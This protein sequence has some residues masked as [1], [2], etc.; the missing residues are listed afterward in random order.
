MSFPSTTEIYNS[1][2][3][4]TLI[5]MGRKVV[6]QT[7]QKKPL[8]FWLSKKQRVTS[9]GG[10][11]IQ[12]PIQ[13]REPTT[14]KSFGRGDSFDQVDPDYLTSATYN[15]RNVGDS[16]TRFWQDEEENTGEQAII[17]LVSQN[18][19]ITVRGL[20]KK[21]Q[22]MIWADTPGSIDISS[23]PFYVSEDPTTGNV[24]DIN[25]ANEPLWRNQIKNA[26]DESAYTTLLTNQLSHKIDCNRFGSI[27]FLICGQ[28][29][30]ELYSAV[31]REQKLINNKTMGDAEFESVGWSGIP[32]MLDTDCQSDRLYS[33]D[34]NS[35]EW[36]V[37]PTADFKWTDWKM[38]PNNLD[39]V[40]QLVLRAQ[41]IFTQLNSQ[42]VHFNITA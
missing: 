26:V 32:L 34:S 15:M 20:Q 38:M 31:A 41:L 25:R 11:A 1:M 7:F 2:Y 9:V 12:R 21:V 18:I 23:L 40:A 10:R 24:A 4:S 42:G 22:E 17:N 30:F 13:L 5:K 3:T 28:G 19:G 33:L 8:F 35:I 14:A 39:R 36:A 16:L 27:D 6:D 37:S 29:V